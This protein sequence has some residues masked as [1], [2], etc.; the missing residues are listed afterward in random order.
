MTKVKRVAAIPA[1]LGVLSLA[2]V[3]G[4]CQATTP[5]TDTPLPVMHTDLVGNWSAEYANDDGNRVS[6][7]YELY[8][9]QTFRRV[10]TV[11]RVT[12]QLVVQQQGDDDKVL[13]RTVVTGTWDVKPSEDDSGTVELQVTGCVGDDC[14]SDVDV[15]DTL[16]VSYT[17]TDDGMIHLEV[18]P[19]APATREPPPAMDPARDLIGTYRAQIDIVEGGGLETV[20]LTFTPSRWIWHSTGVGYQ[21]SGGW[22]ISGSTVTKTWYDWDTQSIRSV[23]KQFSFDGT[24]LIVDPWDYGEP[25][26]DAEDRERY[27]K[28]ENPLPA[29]MIGSWAGPRYEDVDGTPMFTETWRY[30]LRADDTVTFEVVPEPDFV[31]IPFPGADPYPP[32]CH[33]GTLTIDPSELFITFT[34]TTPNAAELPQAPNQVPNIEVFRGKTWRNAYAPTDRPDVIVMS[35][36][37]QE[38]LWPGENLPVEEQIAAVWRDN[39]RFP[40]GGYWLTLTREPITDREPCRW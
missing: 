3:L 7:T 39:P 15:G 29:S 1:V 5:M 10:T 31:K 11:T 34:D 8:N 9:D 40:Y 27:T 13:S 19:D 20:T 32:E 21:Q 22:S 33:H 30:I 36:W 18:A 6:V 14:G 37:W 24:D 26:E 25:S 16:E 4:G 38:Q 23:A 35:T 2:L 28:V 12:A 17:A